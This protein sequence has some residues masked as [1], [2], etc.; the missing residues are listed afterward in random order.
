MS[1]IKKIA[2]NF[3]WIKYFA[4]ELK[5]YFLFFNI[6]DQAIFLGLY[7]KSFSLSFHGVV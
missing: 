3:D 5:N 2:W 6:L 4:Y 1:S 7:L